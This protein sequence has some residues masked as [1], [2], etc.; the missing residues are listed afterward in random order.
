MYSGISTV[1]SHSQSPQDRCIRS[2]DSAF[3]LHASS[4][5]G[6]VSYAFMLVSHECL[7][8]CPGLVLAPMTYAR[9]AATGIPFV[10]NMALGV[11][12]TA[13]FV[14]VGLILAGQAPWR[15]Y[16]KAAAIPGVLAG[17][18]WNAGNVSSFL[19]CLKA[20]C[21]Q[22]HAGPSPHSRRELERCERLPC[23]KMPYGQTF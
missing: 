9:E 20:I 8:V 5:E 18:L 17:C 2:P 10:P 13:P 21:F 3:Q 4:A 11:L 22:M 14:T 1:A 19:S 16:T 23:M 15:L 7:G 6:I 12:I